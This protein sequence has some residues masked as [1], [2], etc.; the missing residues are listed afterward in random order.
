MEHGFGWTE[1]IPGLAA[2]PPHLATALLVMVALLVFALRVR[3]QLAGAPDATVPD[4]GIS[5]RNVAEVLTEMITGLAE[6]VVGHDAPKY[7]PLFGSLFLFILAANLVGLLPGFSPPTDN[8]N[9]T[10]A[11]GAVSFM[12]YNYYGVRTHGFAYLKQFMGPLLLLSPL[13]I[14][15]EGFSH[16]FRPASLAIRLYGNMFADHLLLGIFTD[17]TKVVVPVLFY[18]LGTFVSLV[19]ALVFTLLTMVYVGLAI[20][21]DH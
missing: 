15:V 17:L 2:V 14:I 8:F 21:H 9:I 12:A 1:A 10:F 5:A 20:S 11:L 7:V 13:M 19:Q 4:A 16:L 3:A 18:V 6:G